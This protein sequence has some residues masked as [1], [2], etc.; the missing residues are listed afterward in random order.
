MHKKF[1]FGKNGSRKGSLSGLMIKRPSNSA[2]AQC[3]A[4]T[5]EFNIPT[6]A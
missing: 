2:A 5:G 6:M 4:L 3:Q 1:T